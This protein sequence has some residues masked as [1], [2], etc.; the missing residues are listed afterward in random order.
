VARTEVSSRQDM[1]KRCTE[2]GY[3]TVV[4]GDA[5]SSGSSSSNAIQQG[6]IVSCDGP[7]CVQPHCRLDADL[8]ARSYCMARRGLAEGAW[9]GGDGVQ[10]G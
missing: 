1:C 4:V 7:A 8:A 5:Q 10:R 2:R 6:G 9:R 3:R